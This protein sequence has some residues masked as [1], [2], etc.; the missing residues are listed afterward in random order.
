MLVLEIPYA[1]DTIAFA[2]EE[3]SD[4]SNITELNVIK[5]WNHNNDGKN[6]PYQ[7]NSSQIWVTNR[8]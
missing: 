1:V 6:Q 3:Q 8:Y 2:K 7:V 4:Y 5:Q